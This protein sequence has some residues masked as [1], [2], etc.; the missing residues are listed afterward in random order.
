MKCRNRGRLV[1]VASLVFV[2]GSAISAHADS[3]GINFEGGRP[4]STGGYQTGVFAPSSLAPAAVA[5]VV[6]QAN[7]NNELGSYI[8]GTGINGTDTNLINASGVATGAQLTFSSQ[9]PWAAGVATSTSTPDAIL[10]NGYLDP[11]NSTGTSVSVSNIS[12]GTYD[13]FLYF[14]SG[15]TDARQGIYTVNGVT[16]DVWVSQRSSLQLAGTS[17]SQT[18]TYIEFTDVSGPVL[19][20]SAVP[21]LTNDG[22]SRAPLSG[23]QIVA[24]TPLPSAAHAGF[25]LLSGLGLS[26]LVRRRKLSPSV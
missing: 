10:L 18:G 2:A 7:W 14:D 26:M 22:I 15:S 3:I 17:S 16:Q 24:E 11:Q 19:T 1:A 8:V 9:G 6:G 25:L 13:V 12:Y 5:G 4:S 23:I 21:G 20:V